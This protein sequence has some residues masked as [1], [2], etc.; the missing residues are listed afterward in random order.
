MAKGQSGYTLT[1]ERKKPIREYLD[2]FEKSPILDLDKRPPY[3]IVYMDG[4][5]FH[6]S[7]RSDLSWFELDGDVRNT[8]PKGNGQRIIVLHAI[9]KKGPVISD[10]RREGRKREGFPKLN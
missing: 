6:G 7:Y 8:N 2:D 10:D 4:S 5:N 3:K 1:Q 9:P